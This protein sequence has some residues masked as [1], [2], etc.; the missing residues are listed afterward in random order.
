MSDEADREPRRLKTAGTA[1]ERWVRDHAAELYR[2]AYRMC[3]D[4]EVAED[5]VQE[6]FYEAWKNVR[7]L[8]RP[9]RARAWL[10]QILRHRYSRWKR[11]EHERAPIQIDSTTMSTILQQQDVDH[12]ARHD[13]LQHALNQLNDRLKTPLLMVYMQEMTCEQ[14]A[15]HL[16]LPLG[17]VLSRI[18]RA[19]R[20]LRQAFHE[21]TT[22]RT[23]Q[24]GERETPTYR[25]GGEP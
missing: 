19:K 25:I 3:G 13:E 14:T 24:P 9:D 1:Y 8:R 11:A 23:Q 5:L 7:R 21:Q 15:E 10:Y 12:H 6:T 4:R 16:D 17:T 18:H 22:D 2:F 20:R